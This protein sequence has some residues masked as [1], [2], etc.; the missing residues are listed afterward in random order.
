MKGREGIKAFRTKLQG[1]MLDIFF[2]SSRREEAQINS[3]QRPTMSQARFRC[4]FD[5]GRG[6][7]YFCRSPNDWT[8]REKFGSVDQLERFKK[9]CGRSERGFLGLGEAL[10]KEQVA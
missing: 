8:P 2:C 3:V 7:G 10:A 9:C 1:S 5:Q 4:A 6:A